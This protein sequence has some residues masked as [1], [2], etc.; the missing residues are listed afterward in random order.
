[1]AANVRPD[2]PRRMTL[3]PELLQGM[4]GRFKAWSATPRMR[5]KISMEKTS[6]GEWKLRFCEANCS[7]RARCR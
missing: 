2:S 1:M 5:S 6:W 7:T 3:L 4:A